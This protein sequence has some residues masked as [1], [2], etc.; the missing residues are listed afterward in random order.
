M[1]RH[2]TALLLLLLPLLLLLL[3]SLSRPS[4]P[5]RMA[6]CENTRTI[7]TLEAP[8][9]TLAKSNIISWPLLEQTRW[10]GSGLF[11]SSPHHFL[12]RFFPPSLGEP[13]EPQGRRRELL[14]G[15]VSRQGKT[16]C[17]VPTVGLAICHLQLALGWSPSTVDAQSHDPFSSTFCG[18][19][20][21]TW[22]ITCITLT[23]T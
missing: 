1:P 6:D 21:I 9:Y 22:C 12:Y 4:L 8:V 10:L 23:S 7:S 11:P 16:S 15:E 13:A 18:K 14:H 17:W 20:Q 2:Q 19:G 5:F 3:L